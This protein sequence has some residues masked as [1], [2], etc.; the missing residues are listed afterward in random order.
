MDQIAGN[1]PT[2]FPATG[3]Y[4]TT[5]SFIYLFIYSWFNEASGYL[6]YNVEL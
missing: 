5:V 4:M 6:D 1:W 2:L 3:V